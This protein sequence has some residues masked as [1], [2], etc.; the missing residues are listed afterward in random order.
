M[1]NW[2]S[3]RRLLAVLLTL[4]LIVMLGGCGNKAEKSEMTTYVMAN[5]LVVGDQQEGQYTS[6]SCGK[7]TIYLPKL[8]GLQD[9]AMEKAL[10]DRIWEKVVELADAPP[11][12]YRG[13]KVRL[14]EDAVCREQWINV[15]VMGSF[16]DMLSVSFIRGMSYDLPGEEYGMYLNQMQTLNLDLHTGEEIPLAEIF[17][18]GSD[19][20][21]ML[22][23][24][25][26][27]ELTKNYATEEEGYTMST[28]KQVA[29]FTG[30]R[31][32]QK[33]TISPWGLT[34]YF[35]EATPEFDTDFT[36]ENLT[37]SNRQLQSLGTVA[38]NFYQPPGAKS[39]YRDASLQTP[40]L[41]NWGQTYDRGVNEFLEGDGVYV[42]IISQYSSELPQTVQDKIVELAKIDPTRLSAL[43]R[44]RTEEH[45]TASYDV[46]V[47]AQ[48]YGDY[49]SVVQGSYFYDSDDQTIQE[50]R[51]VYR[52]D[53]GEAVALEDL[54]QP[55]FDYASAI[56]AALARD[57]AEE[58]RQGLTLEELYQG[59][60]W[61]VGEQGIEIWLPL[62]SGGQHVTAFYRD[63]GPEN[64]V[65]FH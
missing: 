17:P 56:K 40:Y 37:I 20:S 63:M 62:E 61:S 3:R 33:Y 52:A 8:S 28:L 26:R 29:P 48:C 27:A 5:G 60:Q 54:F 23:Q 30:I 24:A 46:T 47:W 2:G 58:T 10:N 4:S 41:I 45:P 44:S 43:Q 32:E 55:G 57:L 18:K 7:T 39:I 6:Q 31:P 53:S 19:Y 35:D 11:P 64:M 59:M 21:A 49:I 34:L 36:V 9:A 50:K 65:I 14:P 51:F 13:I 16:N 12:A 1:S 25:V 42:S 22:D 15:N 38:Q